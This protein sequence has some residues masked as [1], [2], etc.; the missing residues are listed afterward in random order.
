MLLEAAE[1]MAEADPP[2]PPHVQRATSSQIVSLRPSPSAGQRAFRTSAIAFEGPPQSGSTYIC[3]GV[4]GSRDAVFRLQACLTPILTLSSR[5]CRW[6]RKGSRTCRPGQR[7]LERRE[8]ARGGDQEGRDGEEDEE[9]AIAAWRHRKHRPTN[10]TE[11]NARRAVKEVVYLRT[12]QCPKTS[13][14]M[15]ERFRHARPAVPD[16]GHQGV[17]VWRDQLERQAPALLLQNRG[18]QSAVGRTGAARNPFP[19]GSGQRRV[20]SVITITGVESDSVVGGSRMLARLTGVKS[21]G[22]EIFPERHTVRGAK[23]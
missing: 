7:D 13:E 3:I 20:S 6:R 16:Q 5:Q 21:V 17:P 15:N 4:H 18:L 10:Y 8:A 22:S 12:D 1:L 19:R 23:L 9:E 2:P 11:E 14:A